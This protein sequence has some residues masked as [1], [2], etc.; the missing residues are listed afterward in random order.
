MVVCTWAV[1]AGWF[2]VSNNKQKQTKE[3]FCLH[4]PKHMDLKY[5]CIHPCI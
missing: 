2:L 3:D 5:S 1:E 4:T